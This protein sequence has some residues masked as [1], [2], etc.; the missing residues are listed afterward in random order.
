[1]TPQIAKYLQRAVPRYTSY[2]TAPHFH[3]GVD[4]AAYGS[5]LSALDPAKPISLYLHIPFCRQVCWY[6]GCHM[7]LL[8]TRA[9]PLT[10]YLDT[11]LDEMALVATALPARMAVS[12]IHFGGGTPTVMSG[13]DLA[14]V[15]KTIN[16]HFDVLG[17]A[18]LAIEADPRTFTDAMAMWLGALGF[19][20]A[21]FGVQEFDPTVQLAIN[22]VQPPEMVARAVES[23][24]REGVEKIN[25]DLIYGL[26][27]QTAET[28]SSTVDAAIAM[29]P[30]RIALFGYAHVPWR[31]KRQRKIDESAL[32]GP[33]ARLEQAE[34]AADALADGGM[35][36][37]GLDHFAAPEDPLAR[38]ALEG[39]LR[40]NFQGYTT[41]DAKTLIGLG[42]TSIGRTP[43]GYV[44][45]TAETG[46]WARSIA[47]GLLPVAKGIAL[48][49]N[50]LARAEVI[51]QLM[52]GQSADTA[53]IARRHGVDPSFAHEPLQDLQE[54]AQEGFL[55]IDDGKVCMTQAG[56][57]LMR[58]AAAA[59]DAYLSESVG[60]HSVAV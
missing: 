48:S 11:L 49:P 8:G 34:R 17:D 23:L 9:Q 56:R 27:F 13:Q 31:A 29:A 59:F 37:V 33:E 47:L 44:Q 41:D 24:R 21:S 60:R 50:D 55:T 58:V 10:S 4:S 32:P 7:K 12:H 28:L 54:M 18:E 5:W 40:R 52:C 19:N 36:P 1:M 45:N 30:D 16:R 35:V 3:D 51:E 46:A 22:R 25:F 43:S 14:R 39:K 26:P 53:A 20:R 15:M 57:P 38:A 6:C 42:A 2:P